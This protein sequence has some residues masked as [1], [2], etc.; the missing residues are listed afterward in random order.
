MSFLTNKKSSAL[1][2]FYVLVVYIIFQFIWWAYSII[3]L[4]HEIYLLKTELINHQSVSD[5]QYYSSIKNLHQTLDKRKWMVMGEG[6]VFIGF[7]ILGIYKTQQAFLKELELSKQQKNFLMAVTHE[8]K[9]PIASSKLQLE[10]LLK[11]ELPKEKQVNLLENALQDTIRL[12]TLV[13]NI[14]TSTQIEN[15]AYPIHKQVENISELTM[16]IV[17]HIKQVYKEKITF[18]LAIAPDVVFNSDASAIESILLNLIE[19]AYKYRHPERTAVVKVALQQLENKSLLLE[20]SDN[21]IGI[22]EKERATIFKKFYRIGD[23]ETRSSKGTG[24]GLFIVKY[25]VKKHNGSITIKNNDPF[26]SIFSI[27]LK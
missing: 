25:F 14:L 15:T 7:L 4:N 9:S 22:P 21:G 5:E 27:N 3:T 12:Q 8:L 26:G 23:E 16:R 10:T 6:I 11:R 13:D 2:L 19:N 24:L 18:Q 20:I 17:N 1:L